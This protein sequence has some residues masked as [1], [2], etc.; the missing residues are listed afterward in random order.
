VDEGEK[1]KSKKKKNKHKK[2]HFLSPHL[3]GIY[4]GISFEM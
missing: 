4:E 3:M 2:Y 1:E